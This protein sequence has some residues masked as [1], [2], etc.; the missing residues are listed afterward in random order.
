MM[1]VYGPTKREEGERGLG[2]AEKKWSATR[3]L[4]GGIH[5]GVGFR[6]EE[7]GDMDHVVG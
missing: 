6:G 2:W 7:G 1:G 3:N 4:V 5:G